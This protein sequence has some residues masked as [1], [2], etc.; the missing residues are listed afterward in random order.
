MK[1]CQAGEEQEAMTAMQNLLDAIFDAVI[2][3]N[4]NFE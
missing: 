2:Q 3:M 4:N 1:Q